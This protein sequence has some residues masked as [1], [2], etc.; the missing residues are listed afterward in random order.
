MKIKYL[1]ICEDNQDSCKYV[2]TGEILISNERLYTSKVGTC[3]ILMFRL[4]DK[5]IMAHIDAG[6]TK[7]EYLVKEIKNNFDNIDLKLIKKIY[8]I[9]GPWCEDNCYYKKKCD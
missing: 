7:T 6:V 1:S 9:I 5:N 8:L 3:S 4:L 2:E